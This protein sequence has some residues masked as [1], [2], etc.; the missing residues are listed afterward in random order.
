MKLLPGLGVSSRVGCRASLSSHLLRSRAP[1]F[2]HQEDELSSE[3]PGGFYPT[4]PTRVNS[5]NIHT[6]HKGRTSNSY[7]PFSPPYPTMS[8]ISALQILSPILS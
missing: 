2:R 5:G 3:P 4:S 6:V 7:R 1:T 8:L